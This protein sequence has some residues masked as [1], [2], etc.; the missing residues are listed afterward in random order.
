M[1]QRNEWLKRWMP[2]LALVLAP[3]VLLSCGPDYEAE[4]E[5]ID[6]TEPVTT[7]GIDE[8]VGTVT[9]TPQEPI[10][11]IT[12][13]P[14]GQAEPEPQP[15]AGGGQM[16]AAPGPVEETTPG[17]GEGE[18]VVGGEMPEAEEVGAGNEVEVTLTEYE[19]GMPE[20]LPAGPTTFNV[21]N[22]GTMEH[23]IEIEGQGIEDALENNL[24][25][26]ESA[27][28]QVDLQPGEYR[29]YCPVGNHAEEG[30]DMTLTVEEQAETDGGQE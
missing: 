9:P 2:V 17:A 22:T 19:I 15:P 6:T 11:T 21:S 26:G 27:T 25:A 18:L 5:G 24:K 28:L 14:G 8:G 16:G 20:T 3:L 29:V 30:M 10:G 4:D 7:P 12:P 23:N 13:A 1:R